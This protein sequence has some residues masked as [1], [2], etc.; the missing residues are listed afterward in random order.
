MDSLCNIPNCR[1]LTPDTEPFCWTHRADGKTFPQ[2]S[3]Q[4]GKQPCGECRLRQGETCDI[5][6]AFQAPAPQGDR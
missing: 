1:N 5:C 4:D 2:P 6:G 3:R